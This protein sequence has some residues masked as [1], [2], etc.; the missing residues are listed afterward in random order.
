MSDTLVDSTFLDA[1]LGS[2]AGRISPIQILAAKIDSLKIVQVSLSLDHSHAGYWV[3][4]SYLKES[5][6]QWRT[7]TFFKAS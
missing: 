6:K 5:R 3:K 4:I 1:A 2:R 7:G